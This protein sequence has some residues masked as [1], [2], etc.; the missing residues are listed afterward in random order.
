MKGNAMED[1]DT[2]TYGTRSIS[3]VFKNFFENLAKTLLTKL[4]SSTEKY[5]LESFITC[6]SIFTIADD[7]C[8]NNTSEDKIL[9][10]IKKIDISK[11]AG[12]DRLSGYIL[13]DGAEVLLR[14]ISENCNLS[15]SREVF[16]DACRVAK[17]KAI[18]K[19]GK[20]TDPSNYRTT[21]LFPVITKVTERIVH[22]QI[23]TFLL[24]TFL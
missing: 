6:Y 22:D 10:I 14:P 7:F 17:L 13:P 2:L 4:P 1:N 12:I 18:Y 9:K 3:T 19:K 21:S 8:L 20:K 11:A 16:P 5:N 15:I 24:N 23:N